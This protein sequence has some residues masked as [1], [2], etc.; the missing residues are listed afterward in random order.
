MLNHYYDIN[1]KEDNEKLYNLGLSLSNPIRI[2]ILSQLKENW[3]SVSELAKLNFV[4]LS[5]IMFHLNVLKK[6]DL[7]NIKLVKGQNGEKT[8]ISR[9]CATIKINFVTSDLDKS[10]IKHYRQSQIVG[11]YINASFGTKSGIVTGTNT[12]NIYLDSPFISDRFKAL[13]IYTNYGSVEYGF[14]NSEFKE[15]KILSIQFSL[16]ICSETSY[17]DNTYKSDISFSINDIFILTYT[18]PGDYGGRKGIYTPDFW[19]VDS[20]QYGVLKTVKVDEH[21]IYLDGIFQ[22]NSITINNLNLNKSNLIKFRVYNEKNALNKG[23]FNI[24]S[25]DFGDYN[26]D[27]EMEVEYE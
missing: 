15:R 18:C 13:L 19:P 26:Q 11:G 1:K 20:T 9:S 3:K 2:A 25:K 16:E 4:S 12:P 27:I 8:M 14:D 10:K 7:I 23:G 22:S 24:F 6:A 17:Y 21:G 5:S